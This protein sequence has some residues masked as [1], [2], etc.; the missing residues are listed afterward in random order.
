MSENSYT[1]S[2]LSSTSASH[3]VATQYNLDKNLTCRFY[4]LGLH[5]N[6]LLESDQQQ[7]ILRIYRNHWRKKEDIL[8]ELETLAFLNSKTDLVSELVTTNTGE[9]AFQIDSPE[10][11]RFAALFCYADGC[12]PDDKISAKESELLGETVALIHKHLDQF[13]PQTS[14]QVLDIHYLL[15]TSIQT[16]KP[17]LENDQ[18][19]YLSQLAEQINTSMPA[20]EKQISI[21]GLC[22]GDVNP[23]NFHINSNDK[24][25]VFDFDQCGFA[26]RSFEIGKFFSSVHRY[27]KADEIKN[28]FLAG[29]QTVRRLSLAEQTAIPWFEIISLIWVMSIHVENA[30]RIGYKNLEKPFWHKRLS[31]IKKRVTNLS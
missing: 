29:Y 15:H 2:Q 12:S 5:D 31:D 19:A 27:S 9:L 25:T 24:I 13:T 1:Y 3:L 4:V 6:Y 23:T 21:F 17:F 8:F 7:Y 16:I 26:Y 18:F 14:R 28:A 20:L 30:D 10:G 11:P 22:I